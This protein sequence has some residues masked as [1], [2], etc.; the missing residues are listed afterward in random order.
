MRGKDARLAVPLGCKA[1]VDQWLGHMAGKRGA[2]QRTDGAQ[3]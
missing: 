1:G 3:R 2:R